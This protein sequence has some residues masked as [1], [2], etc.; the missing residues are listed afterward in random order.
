MIFIP[1]TAVLDEQKTEHKNFRVQE[2]QIIVNKRFTTLNATVD[3]RCKWVTYV[4]PMTHL[5]HRSSD[6]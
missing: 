6:P 4:R 2:F 1:S 3:Q 5:T